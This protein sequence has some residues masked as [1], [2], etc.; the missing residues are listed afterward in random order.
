MFEYDIR[1]YQHIIREWPRNCCDLQEKFNYFSCSTHE[2]QNK[3]TN[4]RGIL[5]LWQ[6]MNMKEFM[7]IGFPHIC[8]LVTKLCPTL[9]NPM[10]SSMPGIP[11]LHYLPEF[12]ATHVH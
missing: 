3:G 1:E 12:A 5:W 10:D 6:Q 9:C 11:V 4:K 7:F 2:R 8:G